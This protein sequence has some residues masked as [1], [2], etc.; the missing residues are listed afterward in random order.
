MVPAAFV[1]MDTL[2]LTPSGKVDRRALPAP[3]ASRA[4]RDE[5][6]IAPETPLEETLAEIWTQALGIDQLGIYDNVFKLGA[7]SLVATQVIHQINATFEINLPLRS[8][9]EEPTVAGLAIL[10]EQTLI[11]QIKEAAI[12]SEV[13]E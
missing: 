1:F 8:L 3:E 6:Y 4:E 13:S 5:E 10:I 7:H 11:N 12:D 2:P 9:F